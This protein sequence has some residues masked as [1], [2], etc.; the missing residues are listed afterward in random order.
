MKK[1]ELTKTKAIA[2]FNNAGTYLQKNSSQKEKLL[3]ACQKLL[4]YEPNEKL[5][6]E[7]NKRIEKLTKKLER[8]CRDVAYDFASLKEDKIICK[9]EKGEPDFTVEN[10]KLYNKKVDELNDKYQEEI[11]KIMSEKCFLYL[12]LVSADE[13]PIRVAAEVRFG[14][15]L[16]IQ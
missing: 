15:S 5:I 9:N 10:Q 13:V 2:L 16:L 11:E 7:H 6:S 1:T 8:D 3:N 12:P 14:L 4:E